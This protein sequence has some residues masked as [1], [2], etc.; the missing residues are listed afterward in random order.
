MKSVDQ[1]RA[2]RG[3]DWWEK[4]DPT[5]QGY[6]IKIRAGSLLRDEWTNIG[7]LLYDY[8]GNLVAHKISTDRAI[9]RGD[10]PSTELAC[11]VLEGY[12]SSCRTLDDAKQTRERSY[13]W[14]CIQITEPGRCLLVEGTFESLCRAYLEVPEEEVGED[15]TTVNS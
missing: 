1:L 4:P 5:L 11:W 7:V 10:L 8:E 2:E 6:V 14:S 3:A 9:R 12:P 13:T 15:A